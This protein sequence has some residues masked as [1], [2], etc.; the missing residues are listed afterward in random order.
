MKSRYLSRWLSNDSDF[1]I[2]KWIYD[3]PPSP[4][5]LGE[6]LPTKRLNAKEMAKYEHIDDIVAKDERQIVKEK[7][8]GTH[9]GGIWHVCPFCSYKVMGR[10]DSIRSHAQRLTTKKNKRGEISEQ[11]PCANYD[12]AW[13]SFNVKGIYFPTRESYDIEKLTFIG[14]TI[15]DEDRKILFLTDV[16]KTA[17]Q[18]NI[19]QEDQII[20]EIL[21]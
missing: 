11:K 6:R 8:K 20:K 17:E 3:S 15:K 7:K 4:Q 2:Y 14:I 1:L 21:S 12:T 18:N 9:S 10:S 16:F 13:S 5:H 19:S